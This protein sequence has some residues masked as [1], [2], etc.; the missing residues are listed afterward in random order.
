MNESE[1]L[2]SR[3]DDQI[4]W[5]SKKSTQNKRWFYY[6]RGSELVIAALIPTLFYLE[7]VK[8]FIPL[9]GALVTIL[10]GF[11]SLLKFQELWISYRTTSESLK[12]HKFLYLTKT[13]PYSSDIRLS[14]LVQNIESL[15]SKENSIWENKQ[16]ISNS[17]EGKNDEKNIY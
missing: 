7:F 16:Q 2:K 1:Y 6:L 12:H 3:L 11:L 5:Y 10:L 13:S 17:L 8:A 4:K 9:L 14:I 15:I